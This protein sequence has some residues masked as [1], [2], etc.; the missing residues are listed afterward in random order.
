MT[1]EKQHLANIENAKLGGVKTEAGKERSKYNAQKHGILR[2]ALSEYE[3]SMYTDVFSDLVESLQPVGFLEV[4]LVER[5]ALC[6]LRLFRAAK[7][8][9][10]LMKAE[11]YPLIVHRW[12]DPLREEISTVSGLDKV[13]SIEG[14]KAQVST[15]A[16]RE[17]DLTLLRYDTGIE[18][19]LYKALHEFQ[20]LQ[21]LRTG[22]KLPSPSVIG[23]T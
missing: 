16:I 13:T 12:A 20:R 2:Q 14:Y 18:N 6:Y 7:A 22:I 15:Q 10:E 5:I 23:I 9:G 21:S 1:S 8:E 4:M 19:R 11:L 17:L 3:G